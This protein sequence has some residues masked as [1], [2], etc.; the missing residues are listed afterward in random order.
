M[1]KL[2]SKLYMEKL[3]LAYTGIGSLPFSGNSAP[4][5]ANDFVFKTCKDF[6]YWP[7]LPHYKMEDRGV[8]TH[9][10][11]IYREVCRA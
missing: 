11:P 8:G 7:Q 9:D 2:T 6:P 1:E 5:D 10:P 3:S 4:N